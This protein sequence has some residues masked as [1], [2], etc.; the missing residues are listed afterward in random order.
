MLVVIGIMSLISGL[1][2]V[3][4]NRFGGVILLQN[5][6][7]DIALSI[8]QAQVYGTAV[9]RFNTSFDAAYGMHFQTNSSGSGQAIY[10]LFADATIVNGL[11][12]PTSELVQSTSIAT[13]YQISQLCI[14][15]AGSSERCDIDSLDI[16]FQ[17]P[18][19]DAYIRSSGVAG[20]GEEGEIHISSPRGDTK[21]ISIHANGQISVD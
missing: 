20:L 9:Q 18:E 11:Y 17:R 15:P 10:V 5:L 4:N 19:S 3:N 16:S 13:G 14:T 1:M 8:R 21:V 12:D 2:L 7:Y 6:A